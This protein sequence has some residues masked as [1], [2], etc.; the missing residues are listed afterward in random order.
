[1][2][3]L[4]QICVSYIDE[5]FAP[6]NMLQGL[7]TFKMLN[8]NTMPERQDASYPHSRRW[9]DRF[10]LDM[11]AC[12]IAGRKRIWCEAVNISINGARVHIGSTENISGNIGLIIPRAGVNCIANIVWSDETDIGVKF[13]KKRR[14]YHRVIPGLK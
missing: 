12:V 10:P 6:H 11:E 8:T 1:M 3:K 14:W 7:E 2:L 4:S 9:S 13:I 5:S